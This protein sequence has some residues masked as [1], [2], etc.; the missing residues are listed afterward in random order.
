MRTIY[1][2]I[3][4]LCVLFLSLL[5]TRSLACTLSLAR[6][7]LHICKNEQ[8]QQQQQKSN[9][10]FYLLCFLALRSFLVFIEEHLRNCNFIFCF[11]FFPIT[12][13]L[14]LATTMTFFFFFYVS[15]CILSKRTMAEQ[16]IV[17]WFERIV[18][19]MFT[20]VHRLTMSIHI[21]HVFCSVRQI[22]HTSQMLH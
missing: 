20:I 5:V 12:L 9:P 1:T 14:F 21:C 10:S 3:H 17:R 6:S 13:F 18:C 7:L 2:Y 19:E 11:F 16:K 8:N 15:L 22:K 4:E